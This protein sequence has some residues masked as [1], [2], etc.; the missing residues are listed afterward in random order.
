MGEFRRGEYRR[1][2]NLITLNARLTNAQAAATCGHE[3]GHQRFG[4]TCSTRSTERRAWQYGAAL[5]ISPL[6]Y[7]AAERQV[8]HHPAALAMELRVTPKLIH[9]WRDWWAVRGHRLPRDDGDT[10]GVELIAP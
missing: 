5:L 7:E 8:G 10:L 3:L 1:Y 6:E 2:R 4:D 9:S